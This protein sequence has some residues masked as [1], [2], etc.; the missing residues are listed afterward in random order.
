MKYSKRHAYQFP[1]SSPIDDTNNNSFKSQF[2]SF[3]YQDKFFPHNFPPI[4]SSNDLTIFDQW[5]LE[6]RKITFEISKYR[7]DFHPSAH[8]NQ[9]SILFSFPIIRETMDNPSTIFPAI[10]PSSVPD[11]PEARKLSPPTR[12]KETTNWPAR[13]NLINGSGAIKIER[14][15]PPSPPDGARLL[16]RN[17]RA[18][19]SFSPFLVN[20]KC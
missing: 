8:C 2:S 13:R 7:I 18:H 4:R 1:L 20:F 15:T 10:I 19:P 12:S 16:T 11:I 3:Q 9:L 6:P 5:A 17:S 14:A